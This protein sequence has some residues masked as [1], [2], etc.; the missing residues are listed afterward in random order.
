MNKRL[1]MGAGALIALALLFAGITILLNRAVRG[2]RI[3]LTQNHLYTTAPAP[4][5]SRVGPI[6]CSSLS[7]GTIIERLMAGVD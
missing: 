1:T 3:D 6:A 5:A 4:I 2:W 7:I